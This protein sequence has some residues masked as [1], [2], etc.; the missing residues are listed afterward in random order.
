MADLNAI[1]AMALVA[2]ITGLVCTYY[3]QMAVAKVAMH[4]WARA[5]AMH[6][7]NIAYKRAYREMRQ[8][9]ADLSPNAA[10]FQENEGE[11]KEQI[12]WN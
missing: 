7:S 2:I 5:Y 3:S 4:F 12:A 1:L 8:K 9:C 11:N 6:I 10:E